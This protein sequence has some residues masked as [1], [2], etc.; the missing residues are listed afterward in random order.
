MHITLPNIISS[1]VG[2]LLPRVN[3]LY[4]VRVYVGVFRVFR[5]QN[6]SLCE[7]EAFVE[8]LVIMI[9]INGLH[10]RIARFSSLVDCLIKLF[11]FLFVEFLCSI[12]TAFLQPI[13]HLRID[14]RRLYALKPLVC[15]LR[16][17]RTW[18]H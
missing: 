7:Y 18:P 9:L 15:Y 10:D 14:A 16:F 1:I 12:S 6:S 13:F 5:Q 17:D 4:L 3:V 8:V 2:I 11:I